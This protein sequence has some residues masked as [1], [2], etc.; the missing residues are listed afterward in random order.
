M[1][2]KTPDELAELKA[3]R[4]ADYEPDDS[5]EDA[6]A[7]SYAVDGGMVRGPGL[8]PGAGDNS[9]DAAAESLTQAAREKLK[10]VIAG[11]E[12][13]EEEQRDLAGVKRDK[14]AEAKAM[15]YDTKAIRR[16]VALRKIDH[17]ERQE[18]Q[19]ILDTYLHAIGEL[20]FYD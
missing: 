3:I 1:P 6:A 9:G 11:I 4:G 12:K 5:P 17:Q 8:T 16:V 20:E 10:Q 15:G 18:Q 7:R 13:V 2:L 19:A 14:Y